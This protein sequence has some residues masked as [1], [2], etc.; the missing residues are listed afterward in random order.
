[1]AT[2]AP[3]RQVPLLDDDTVGFGEE[4]VVKGRFRYGRKRPL[5]VA[6]TLGP[7]FRERKEPTAHAINRF[8]TRVHLQFDLEYAALF[9]SAPKRGNV[10]FEGGK[11][12]SP[13][14]RFVTKRLF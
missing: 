10:C 12:R 6:N 7:R 1:M 2:N 11:L 14:D 4:D 3:V 8:Q 9:G 5:D 13:E